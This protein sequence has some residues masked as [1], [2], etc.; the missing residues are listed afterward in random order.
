M[1]TYLT[2]KEVADELGVSE[3]WV[4]KRAQAR[5]IAFYRIAG[6]L[7]F[8]WTDVARYLERHKHEPTHGTRGAL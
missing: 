1:S 3:S 2:A 4:K 6:K 5:E 7:R 8:K